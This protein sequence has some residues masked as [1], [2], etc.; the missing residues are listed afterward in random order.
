[1]RFSLFMTRSLGFSGGTFGFLPEVVFSVYIVELVQVS[2][3]P[4]HKR[5]G[6]YLLLLIFLLAAPANRVNYSNI[7]T[8]CLRMS[9]P[10]PGNT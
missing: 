2:L 9:I 7:V 5:R 4:G 10:P 8:F 1:M 6:G 3:P